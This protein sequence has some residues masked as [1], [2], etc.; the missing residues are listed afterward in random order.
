MPHSY[1]RLCTGYRPDHMR[2]IDLHWKQL[3]LSVAI[4][5]LRRGAVSPVFPLLTNVASAR[6]AMQMKRSYLVLPS[7]SP[8][9][10]ALRALTT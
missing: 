10:S 6:Y 7:T 2:V 4:C 5:G 8:T 3:V 1:R 9:Y